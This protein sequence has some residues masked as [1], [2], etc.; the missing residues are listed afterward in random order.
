MLELPISEFQ[1]GSLPIDGRQIRLV[2][3][4]PALN[5][6][7]IR[8]Q[9]II[10]DVNKPPEYHALSY[11]WGPPLPLRYIELNGQPM[12]VRSNLANFLSQL[13]SHKHADWV[14]CDAICINQQDDKERSEQVQM[15]GR[16]YTRARSVLVWLGE[17]SDGSDGLFA[18]LS[19]VVS[20]STPP[21]D[22][23]EGSYF[24][25]FAFVSKDV[26]GG[27][28]GC[29]EAERSPELVDYP[30]DSETKKTRHRTQDPLQAF[31]LPIYQRFFPNDSS[32]PPSGLL[33]VL[34][35]LCRRAY[36]KRTWILQEVTLAREIVLYCGDQYIPWAIFQSVTM[37]TWGRFSKDGVLPEEYWKGYW[38][39][40]IKPDYSPEAICMSRYC[41]R[42]KRPPRLAYLL[43]HHYDMECTDLRDKIYGLLPISKES[44]GSERI[45]V[46]YTKSVAEVFFDV[47]ALRGH[48]N[49]R[50]HALLQD[51]LHLNLR[52]LEEVAHRSVEVSHTGRHIS[53]PRWSMACD[54]RPAG[55]V[56]RVC[57]VTH[58]I[59]ITSTYS[60]SRLSE[61]TYDIVN[62][63][64]DG[65]RLGD[66][67]FKLL[68]SEFVLICQ[69]VAN[70]KLLTIAVAQTKWLK[71]FKESSS[72]LDLD[73]TVFEGLEIQSHLNKAC[74]NQ[75][76]Y[77]MG[78]KLADT[79]ACVG[80]IV[81]V[82]DS[83][84]DDLVNP[85]W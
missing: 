59:S 79:G 2:K 29:Q 13:I 72:N 36:W 65:L 55:M 15:M 68:V 75:A 30:F 77:L 49:P 53:D 41:Y 10:P 22:G 18:F 8:C 62:V 84:I 24:P 33:Q 35:H 5:Q 70:S 25:D 16:I 9:M 67:A 14:W 83:D 32:P 31:W 20:A 19:A 60:H 48:L 37:Q 47:I 56:T 58:S 26:D 34:Y 40:N 85:F 69:E 6:G 66:Q 21:R 74:L 42:L 4:L 50:F 28:P 80:A 71:Q 61:R 12:R 45:K 78:I 81:N 52:D 76:Q 43:E 7:D 54:I 57:P 3:L 63:S 17:H 64:T 82:G 51:I 73:L 44:L 38:A 27:L 46:D 23:S 11:T 39:Y 1:Y